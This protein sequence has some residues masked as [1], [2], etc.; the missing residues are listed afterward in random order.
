MLLSGALP[1]VPDVA[2]ELLEKIEGLT[3][4]ELIFRKGNFTIAVRPSG[5]ITGGVPSQVI[6]VS[7]IA[8]TAK[9]AVQPAA[10]APVPP[11]PAPQKEDEKSGSASDASYSATIDAPFVG[12]LYFSPGP[13]KPDFFKEGDIVDAGAKV[14][15]VEAMKLFNEITAPKRCRIVKCLATDGQSVEKGQPLIG[16][17]EL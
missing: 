4:E 11:Q 6:A 16:I 8:T 3:L 13:G 2:A 1:N 14:C 7:D 10:Q 17:E 12:T 5:Q 15:I 9:P